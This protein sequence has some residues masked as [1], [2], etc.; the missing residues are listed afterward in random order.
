MKESLVFG[1]ET[2]GDLGGL[3]KVPLVSRLETSGTLFNP[4][5]SPVHGRYCTGYDA[6]GTESVVF[7]WP[8]MQS[9]SQ[10]STSNFKNFLGAVPWCS[11]HTK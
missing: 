2:T 6:T 10:I 9:R 11:A 5:K 8:I 3:N 4:P 7:N 1:P